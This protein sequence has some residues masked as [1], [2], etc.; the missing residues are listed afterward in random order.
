MSTVISV[1]ALAALAVLALPCL[2]WSQEPTAPADR[3]TAGR[4]AEAYEELERLRR[5]RRWQRSTA[6]LH[7]AQLGA[8]LV[9]EDA[10]R[11]ILAAWGAGSATAPADL[12]D[13]QQRVIDR[14]TGFEVDEGNLDSLPVLEAGEGMPE[15]AAAPARKIAA[16]LATPGENPRRHD[17][18]AV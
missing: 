17:G 7:D 3:E 1:P 6:G 9:V 8:S 14:K 5:L 11:Q 12:S 16:G 15:L 13:W 2:A 4:D 10:L 18:R